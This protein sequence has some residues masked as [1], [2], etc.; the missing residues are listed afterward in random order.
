MTVRRVVPLLVC[1]LATFA[2]ALAQPKKAPAP[3]APPAPAKDAPVPAAGSGSGSADAPPPVDE[4]PPPDMDG[5]DE[6]P[7]AP[8]PLPGEEPNKVVAAP[9]KAVKRSGYPIEEVLRPITLPANMAEVAIGPRAVIDADGVGYAGSD[10]LRARYGITRQ[11]QIGLNYVIGAIYDDPKTNEDKIGFHPGK[12]LELQVTYLVTDFLGVRLGVPVWIYKP[13]A[14]V[15]SSSPAFGLNIGVPLKFRFGDKLAIGG[16]DD[17]LSI[18]IM[19]FA[20]SLELEYLN[21][22]RAHSRDTNT[23]QSAGF[24]RFSGYAVYQQSP[25]LALIGRFGIQLEDFSTRKTDAGGGIITSLRAGLEY[26]VKTYL[27]VGIA[28]G[29]EDLDDLGSFGPTTLLAFRI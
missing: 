7:G 18:R 21:A 13:G 26:T 4:G 11:I 3:K 14:N 10:T 1:L 29:F 2:V 9:E 6:N 27:D 23:S 28:L 22:Y 5:K 20:P 17:L 12:A 25:K 8:K 16:L 19:Q 15:D 24:I